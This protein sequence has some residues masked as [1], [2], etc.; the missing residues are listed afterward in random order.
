MTTRTEYNARLRDMNDEELV[1]EIQKL[2]AARMEERSG[3]STYG[4][5]YAEKQ[6]SGSTLR[7][8]RRNLARALTEQ[9]L[10]RK[11]NA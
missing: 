11:R 6:R 3:A 8:V 9:S 1:A 7:V 5:G 10:R 4:A 2:R